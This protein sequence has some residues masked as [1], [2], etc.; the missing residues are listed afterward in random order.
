VIKINPTIH[1]VEKLD[2]GFATTGGGGGFATTGG[3]VAITGGGVGNGFAT[4]GGGVGVF[5][6][7]GGG[8]IATL[9]T[10]RTSRTAYLLLL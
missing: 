9:C 4:I 8:V 3:G 1:H 6:V 10:L 5:I 2:D 7:A